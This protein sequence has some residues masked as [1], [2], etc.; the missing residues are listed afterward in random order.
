MTSPEVRSQI[1]AKGTI[2]KILPL[3]FLSKRHGRFYEDLSEFVSDADRV[4]PQFIDILTISNGSKLNIT[5]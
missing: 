1:K 5:V 3:I 2:I 4:S